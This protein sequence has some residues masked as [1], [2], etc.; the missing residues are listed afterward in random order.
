MSFA[1]DIKFATSYFIGIKLSF[2]GLRIEYAL[3]GNSNYIAWEDRME[4]LLED[5]R[6]KGFIEN[7]I[8]KPQT[9]SAQDLLEWR[10]CVE[11]E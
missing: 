6:I 7:D 4:A 3:E 1:G 9:T 10:K 2:Y 11:K 8:P 5:N